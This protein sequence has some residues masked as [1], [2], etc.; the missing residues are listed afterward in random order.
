MVA[1]ADE[2]SAPVS[3]NVMLSPQGKTVEAFSKAV[4]GKEDA[5]TPRRSLADSLN[6]KNVL[7]PVD[8]RVK[9]SPT[10]Q[11]ALSKQ[12]STETHGNPEPETTAEATLEK[13]KEVIDATTEVDEGEE[14]HSD[15]TWD[16]F[17]EAVDQSGM[18]WKDP[19]TGTLMGYAVCDDESALEPVPC[20]E[21]GRDA[22][23]PLQVTVEWQH[24]SS[25]VM[26]GY[27][28]C[29]DHDRDVRIMNDLFEEEEEEEVDSSS[30]DEAE[31]K[32]SV[33]YDYSEASE[34]ISSEVSGLSSEEDMNVDSEACF[35]EL[36]CYE[37]LQLLSEWEDPST[38]TKLG[39][40][41]CFQNTKE[42]EYYYEGE[43]EDFVPADTEVSA[44]ECEE[45]VEELPMM[46]DASC[47][48]ED[49]ATGASLG[50]ECDNDS[51]FGDHLDALPRK[52]YEWEDPDTGVL[53]GYQCVEDIYFGD[54]MH[55]GGDESIEIEA[56]DEDESNVDSPCKVR[57]EPGKKTR[58]SS[59]KIPS[60]RSRR[61]RPLPLRLRTQ[62]LRRVMKSWRFQK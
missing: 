58:K 39:Y 62:H 50:Y 29:D 56:S 23:E 12:V 2:N 57:A 25:G 19:T 30:A 55:E 37:S 3:T 10:P 60:K 27:A 4:I 40:A 18:E 43:E 32:S 16:N 34:V 6:E 54:D 8:E 22:S 20:D 52:T 35:E 28:L 33:S 46:Q 17:D 45:S 21:V 48:W 59:W 61:F 5:S 11:K 41:G 51:D 42:E 26:M 53:L 38:G 36:E 31:S 24:P 7:T 14:D 15:E 47:E 9:M 44:P 13:Y 49:P 1:I